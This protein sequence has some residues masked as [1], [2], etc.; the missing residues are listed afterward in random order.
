MKMRKYL[1]GIFVGVFLMNPMRSFAYLLDEQMLKTKDQSC[2]FYYLTTKNT[3]GWYFKTS[4]E[5]CQN[6]FLNGYA[7]VTVYNAFSKPIEQIYGYFSN[8]YWTGEERLGKKDILSRV[9][10]EYGVQKAFF[11]VDEDKTSDIRY[12][13]QM[14]A[15]KTKEGS[16]TPFSFCKPFKVLAVTPNEALFQNPHTV[17]SLL[18]T[19]QKQVREVCPDEEQIMFF[20]SSEKKPTVEDIFFYADVNLK[21]G[22]TTVKHRVKESV[23]MRGDGKIPVRRE[24]SVV[25]SRFVPNKSTVSLA[26]ADQKV[27]ENNPPLEK[28]QSVSVQADKNRVSLSEQDLILKSS[29]LPTGIEG[30]ELGQESASRE[31]MLKK[32]EKSDEAP[33]TD[34]LTE[35]ERAVFL[36]KAIDKSSLSE[37]AEETGAV[38]DADDDEQPVQSFF[39]ED[40]EEMKTTLFSDGLEYGTVN[41]PEAEESQSL[42]Q[43]LDLKEAEKQENPHMNTHSSAESQVLDKAPHLRVVSRVLKKPVYG[44][45]IVHIQKTAGNTA[46]VDKPIPLVLQGQ[47]L[48]PEWGI[49]SGLF[50][51]PDDK[52]KKD[53]EDV[54]RVSSFMP[55]QEAYCRDF[56]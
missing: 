41:R 53:T 23:A 46:W 34:F 10:D 29:V 9:S 50:I 44:T 7:D 56:R 51:F 22:E 54:V 3:Q 19:I 12:I 35:S 24:K 28:Q 15:R 31:R 38:S 14:N 13:G 42:Q 49:V 17:Q 21:T 30:N 16:Y 26:M 4:S 11:L 18:D 6:G 47:N 2:S 27:S 37:T 33:L 45:A 5:A 39:S 1:L 32:V 36:G 48:V 55:C 25:L 8:G 52:T 43:G 40:D 20:A